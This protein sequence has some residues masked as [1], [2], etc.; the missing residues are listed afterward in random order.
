MPKLSAGLQGI[1]HYFIHIAPTPLFTPLKRPDDGMTAGVVVTGGML[2]W[3][4]IAATNMPAG[5]AESQM[6]PDATNAQ[7]I[8]T[9]ISTRLHWF[10]LIKMRTSLSHCSVHGLL[11]LGLINIRRGRLQRIVSTR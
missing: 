10:N 2:V 7:A 6:Y 11:Q 8:F 5:H 3:R 1:K 9:A 4:R